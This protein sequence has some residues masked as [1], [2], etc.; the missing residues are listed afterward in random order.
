MEGPLDVDQGGRITVLHQ[1]QM[2]QCSHCLR[3]SDSCPGGGRGRYCKELKTKRGE[4]SDYMRHLKVHHNY[5]SLKMKFK[6]EFPQLNSNKALNNG[7]GHMKEALDDEHD[8][9]SADLQQNRV[10]PNLMTMRRY[11]CFSSNC[12]KQTLPENNRFMKLPS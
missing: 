6:E 4:I 1:G 10:L 3:R 8:L 9:D 5:I 7:F 11:S 12:Q 2:M